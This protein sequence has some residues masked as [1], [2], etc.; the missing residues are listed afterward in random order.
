M[1][2]EPLP[3]GDRKEFFRDRRH[4]HERPSESASLGPPPP[5]PPPL[6][7]ARWR[8]SYGSRSEF[9]R[10]GFSP[11]FRR[12][13]GHGK[14][15]GWTSYHEEPGYGYSTPRSANRFMPDDGFR[16]F[17]PRGDGWYARSC[18]ENRAFGPREWRGPSWEN[19]NQ[20]HN[21][22]PCVSA[23]PQDVNDQR[24]VDDALMGVYPHFDSS[25]TSDQVHRKNL[26]SKPTDEN[27]SGMGPR[28]DKE[29]SMDID[30]RPLKW[31]RSGN[32]TS[33][34]SSLGHSSSS[35]GIEGESIDP[36]SEL[37]TQTAAPV[38]TPLGNP[39]ACATSV[40]QL[41][42]IHSKK[43]PRLGWGEGLAKYEKKKVEG[44]D[45]NVDRAMET[46][47]AN[48]TELCHSASSSLADRSPKIGSIVDCASPATASSAACNSS[49][50]LED[51]PLRKLTVSEVDANDASESPC[52][53]PQVQSHVS[54]FNLEDFEPGS[55]ANLNVLLI[56]L[57]Q[58]EDQNSVGPDFLKS[59]AHKLML[60]K[61]DITKV[62][63]ITE[64]EIDSLENEL[65]SL[66]SMPGRESPLMMSSSSLSVDDNELRKQLNVVSRSTIEFTPSGGII[67]EEMAPSPTAGG[68]DTEI[69]D[70][71]I[72]NG[73]IISRYV[74]PP[75]LENPTSHDEQET[76]SPVD[77]V[78][79]KSVDLA[80]DSFIPSS[81][82][83]RLAGPS[84]VSSKLAQES[85]ISD[86]GYGC[87]AAGENYCCNRILASNKAIAV[88]ASELVCKLL[89]TYGFHGNDINLTRV[90]CEENKSLVKK[91]LQRKR[92]MKFKERVLYLKY[93]A[94]QHLWKED[95][96][97][98][99]ARKHRAKSQKKLY[100][101]MQILH[102]QYQKHQSSICSRFTSPA[103]SL[104]LIPTTESFSFTNKL[105]SDS[106]VKLCRDNLRMPALIIDEKE[107]VLTRFISSNGLVEDPCAVERERA[108]I[109][110]WTAEEKE[111][112][113]DKLAIFGKDFKKISSFLDHKTAADCIEFYYKNHKS[114][115]FAGTKN[116]SELKKLEKSL[117]ANTYLVTS[118]KKWS[119]EM[120]SA[121]L[122]LLGE[123]SVFAAQKDKGL[124]ISK[125]G[126]GRFSGK[127]RGVSGC[128]VRTSNYDTEDERE[129]AA[130]DVLA[131]ICGSL[132]SEAMSSCI[133]N[134][135]DPVENCP[136][137]MCRRFSSSSRRPLTPE[138]TQD[139]EDETCSD[140]SCEMDLDDWT[141]EEKSLFVQAFSAH[142]KD[143][144]LISRR[145]QTKS[146]DQCKVF[147][148]KA[149]KCLGLDMVCPDPRNQ[150]TPVSDD[151]DGS[152]SGSNGACVVEVGSIVTSDKSGSRIDE[153]L[154]V[155]TLDK[156][157]EEISYE[158]TNL[159]GE[160]KL[161]G[162]CDHGEVEKLC[163]DDVKAKDPSLVTFN[164]EVTAKTEVEECLMEQEQ[165]QD[166]AVD[167]AV[168][169]ALCSIKGAATAVDTAM[170]DE[171]VDAVG[172]VLGVS[173]RSVL[174]DSTDDNVV[175]EVCAE[176]QKLESVN[177][178]LGNIR[179]I[180]SAEHK[181]DVETSEDD[182]NN[183]SANT[184]LDPSSWQALNCFDESSHILTRHGEVSHKQLSPDETGSGTL[185]D[186][187]PLQVSR[188][189]KCSL[190]VSQNSV[191]E[192]GSNF[193]AK[194]SEYR[195]LS[196][197]DAEKP[198]RC[199]DVKL[200]GKILSKPLP[201]LSVGNENSVH[202]PSSVSL[203]DIKDY[204]H[205]HLNGKSAVRGYDI[206][207]NGGE[208][209]LHVISNG[210]WD[211]TRIRT[212]CSA[213]ADSAMLLANYP[214][215]FENFPV[216]SSKEQQQ[217]QTL[218]AKECLLNSASV[219]KSRDLTGNNVDVTQCQLQ[220]TQDGTW[221][222]RLEFLRRKDLLL[223]LPKKGY[224]NG[225]DSG[226][227]P[228]DRGIVKFNVKVEAS[229]SSNGLSD[230]V[231]ALKL[232]FANSHAATAA[233][234][235]VA[236]G[237]NGNGNVVH[238]EESWR[239]K[240]EVGR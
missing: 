87:P 58:S 135:A 19:N 163:L 137:L 211:G 76:I 228:H 74:K 42:D 11:D 214:T 129:A 103:G 182:A 175:G 119:R 80:A 204:V 38:D 239:G 113:L 197:S 59:S 65:K 170:V 75:C 146:R 226:F 20:Q 60:W 43:K 138:V 183:L 66:R 26:T 121:S 221:P 18:R 179:E 202:H 85:G 213:L 55:I 215:S 132:S 109:N 232:H 82:I 237:N 91:F 208:K 101:G 15:G 212:G 83:L 68:A 33:K 157:H 104:S 54:A 201:P 123:V 130:A 84:E 9:A 22:L 220:Q 44:P 122:D 1:P 29:N 62:L 37:L 187:Q 148:S 73:T 102:N 165:R 133:T 111:I 120:N 57:F 234:V 63:E 210:F 79:A 92:C 164:G 195:P 31:S 94:L 5:P 186:V 3:W 176:D 56:E 203:F 96:S 17:G 40:T 136:D 174:G 151:V 64:S 194:K 124:E 145:V 233:A 51:K 177:K 192:P 141:D 185:T 117:H 147:F 161:M 153:D 7:G 219:Y 178:H 235:V 168:A 217:Q 172:A 200:F 61:R 2:P 144:V 229:G 231:A 97:F 227:Q 152:G 180:P 207:L 50:G 142:G 155:S 69:K 206:A 105:L 188:L 223:D 216:A 81:G 150:H 205:H 149:R 159:Q 90:S 199:G 158:A 134:S 28:A 143:F 41:E 8:D 12:F 13:P 98:L 23:R 47:C 139:I 49:P 126:S 70:E 16:P 230:P 86:C 93:R 6:P 125:M 24:S 89:P 25:N 30:W 190:T 107:K 184:H 72:D 114:E 166:I 127:S 32:L 222:L 4:S 110:P 10:W 236:G 27:G 154:V 171:A 156:E 191:S 53:V 39:S 52:S 198:S 128:L 167:I 36:R 209:N 225:S 169:D 218:N 46:L 35:R 193:P 78:D 115:S 140:E 21:T 131:G 34:S 48:S 162:H 118:G 108:L 224:D 77:M 14:Q 88:Q 116:K 99:S 106:Q 67:L 160:M 71:Q 189:R 240:G 196:P 112:F 95:R 45:E 100:P 238:E 173:G 181:H